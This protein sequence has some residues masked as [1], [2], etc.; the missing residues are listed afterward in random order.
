[1]MDN[2]KK[3]IPKLVIIGKRGWKNTKTFSL[4]N[5]LKRKS[6]NII[7]ISDANDNEVAFLNK[8]SQSVLFPSFTEGFH[9]SMYEALQQSEKVLVSKIEAHTE[10]LELF[11]ESFRN[12]SFISFDISDWVEAIKFDDHKE[13]IKC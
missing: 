4:L 1:M 5:K 6:K 7:E 3:K 12:T 11:D 8:H 2:S 9:L 13:N 10:I